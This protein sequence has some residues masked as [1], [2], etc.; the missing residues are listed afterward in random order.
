M[1]GIIFKKKSR[2]HNFHFKKSK[3]YQNWPKSEDTHSSI[4]STSRGDNRIKM[5]RNQNITILKMIK[6]IKAKER[7]IELD[8]R[9]KEII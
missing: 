5:W 9:L 8:N 4:I 1:K 2:R 6:H 3:I 7:M